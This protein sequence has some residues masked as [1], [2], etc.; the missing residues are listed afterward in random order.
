LG[1]FASAVATRAHCTVEIGREQ[2]GANGVAPE[3]VDPGQ[4][5]TTQ[6]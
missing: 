3:P 4:L 6:P 5:E 2:T 1:G